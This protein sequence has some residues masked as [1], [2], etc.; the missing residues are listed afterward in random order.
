ME[1]VDAPTSAGVYFLLG[2]HRELLYVGKAANLRRRLAD[3]VRSGRWDRVVDVRWELHPSERAAELRESDVLLAL[4]PRHNK[5]HI[6]DYFH[7]VTRAP[8]GLSLAKDGE[9][10]CFP[11]LGTGAGSLTGRTCIDGFNAL[12]RIAPRAE[13]RSLHAFL[14]G[15]RDALEI[16]LEDEQPHVAHGV[17]KDRALAS[18]FFAV[19]PRA[20]RDLRLRHDG[21][22]VVTRD[23]FVGWITA[24]VEELLA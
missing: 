10:G 2:P 7:F 22:G 23:M 3:H 18:Q 1:A 13:S 16:D 19:G 4:R 20:I 5:A 9:Y 11:Q 15:R 24:E 6:D 12:A 8:K 17:R 21:R 14:S